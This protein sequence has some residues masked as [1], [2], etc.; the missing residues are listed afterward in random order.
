M[1]TTYNHAKANA[2]YC[3]TVKNGAYYY[4]TENGG[5]LWDGTRDM[6]FEAPHDS[7][8]VIGFTTRHNGNRII[9]LAEAANGEDIGQGWVHDLDHGTHRMWAMPKYLRARKIIRLKGANS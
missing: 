4:L 2:M 6:A 3:M 1:E 8:R 5:I 9:T 7:W